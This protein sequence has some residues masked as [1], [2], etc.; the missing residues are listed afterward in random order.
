M[1]RSGSS[2]TTVS[3]ASS[4][5]GVAIGTTTAVEPCSRNGTSS[6]Y[7]E[8]SR[9]RAL[10]IEDER[11]AHPEEA[12]ARKLLHGLVSRQQRAQRPLE[13]RVGDVRRTGDEL[14]AAPVLHSDHGRVG[15]EQ[16]DGRAASRH[17]ASRRARGSGRTSARS[18]TAPAGASRPRARP[19]RASSRSEARRSVR[20][21]S[22][23]FCAADRQLAGERREERRLVRRELPP[24]RQVRGEQA[25]QLLA[26]DERHGEHRRRC[27]ASLT[28]SSHRGQPKV[29]LRVRDVQHS[30]RPERAERELE[31]PL[32]DRQLRA[33]ELA[34]LAA[35]SPSPG[36]GTR[37]RG[38]RASSSET[39]VTAVSSVCASE[40]SAIAWPT[41]AEQ[42]LE[43]SSSSDIAS[44]PLA[45]AQRL[46][47]ADGERGE[48][49]ELALRG[50]APAGKTSCEHADRRLAER[51][52]S[53][54]FGRDPSPSGLEPDRLPLGQG[55]T[56]PLLRGSRGRSAPTEASSSSAPS[57]PGY[58]EERRLG[59]GRSGRDADDLVGASA[60]SRPAAS[61]SPASASARAK[62]AR[63]AAAA[64]FVRRKA[65]RTR[66]RCE[67]AN[68][69]A[70]IRRAQTTRRDGTASRL[71]SGPSRRREPCSS[72]TSVALARRAA[73]RTASGSRSP[74]AFV[75][76]QLDERETSSRR[77]RRRAPRSAR[78]RCG[79]ASI[80]S[81]PVTRIDHRLGTGRLGRGFSQRPQRL[82]EAALFGRA[83]PS[84]GQRIERLLRNAVH[85]RFEKYS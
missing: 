75:A 54:P 43:R 65:R 83:A 52:A 76:R 64:P 21:C 57:R 37:P 74:P 77:A 60:W 23:A 28:A 16:L 50:R 62:D 80:P 63:S 2:E 72:T 18:R 13:P 12:A 81:S 56:G 10:G 25:D 26:G 66:P 47:G 68:R 73:R 61:A 6:S 39:R 36:A 20:S 42:G 31:Q 11:P 1:R 55:A 14:V 79:H 9:R 41:T 29:G 51:E 3:V 44:A 24:A 15:L 34:R 59:A 84:G 30:L 70:T 32:G 7:D 48:S 58:P 67:A 4:S 27:C 5:A 8:P 78:R 22:C 35:R 53:P 38:P 46:G 33:G 17:R 19:A 49:V 71:P 40:S 82:V 45:R 85:F 69:A